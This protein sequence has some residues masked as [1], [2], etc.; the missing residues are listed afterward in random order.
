MFLSLGG[1]ECPHYTNDLC[2]MVV[3]RCLDVTVNLI[4]ILSAEVFGNG[5]CTGTDCVGGMQSLA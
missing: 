3:E 2:I 1:F 4:L 5:L